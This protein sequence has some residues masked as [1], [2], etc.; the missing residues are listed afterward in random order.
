[1]SKRKTHLTYT[2][3]VALGFLA[4][5][6]IGAVL[7]CL[8]ISSQNGES[9]PFINALFT[10]T[11]ATCV[12]GLVI[13]DTAIQWSL[14]GQMV[15]ILLIQVGGIGFMTIL[16]MFSMAFRRKINLSERRLLV[17][18]VGS[19]NVSGIVK[20][21]KKILMGTFVFELSGALLLSFRFIPKFGW[22]KGIYFSFFHSVSAFCN[23]GYDIMGSTDGAYASLTA[24]SGDL[25]VSGTIMGLIVIGGI[26]F[27]VWSDISTHKF[28]FTKYS[29]HSKIVLSATAL[30]IIIPAAMFFVFEQAH[31]LEGR[32]TGEQI[33]S[34]L[35][36]SIS[37]RTAGFNTVDLTKVSESGTMLECFLMIVGGSPGSTAGG[38]KTTTFVVLIIGILAT[39]KREKSIVMFKRSIDES[40]MRQA[41][42][43]ASIYLLVLVISTMVIGYFD[44]IPIKE[45]IFQECSAI[46]TVGL[47]IGD[48]ASYSVV[49]RTVLI[50]LMYMGRVGGLTF[51]IILGERHE[52]K[53][54]ERPT[55]KI[56]IG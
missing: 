49:S 41:S 38:I 9:V 39:A 44:P 11:S 10:A 45:I 30:L 16:T 43:V 42:S 36:L 28:N 56:L 7:L 34:S 17:Q 55:E 35:F 27:I 4:I 2:Q 23:A 37:P 13:Y 53:A 5:I 50:M 6:F 8:P 26:G 31:A 1:M 15:I 18:S 25:L 52:P 33:L 12:T 24:Y 47:S 32:N 20:L 51:A 19:I 22:L 54:C 46:G 3:I 14:F 29:L 48:N 21:I 40:S